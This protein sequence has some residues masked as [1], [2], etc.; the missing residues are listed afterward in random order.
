[1]IK[2][3]DNNFIITLIAF[4]TT[5]YLLFLIRNIILP[6]D[7]SPLYHIIG[8]TALLLFLGVILIAEKNNKKLKSQIT[9]LE[10]ELIKRDEKY[11]SEIEQLS[12]NLEEYEKEKNESKKFA[13]YRDKMLK[14]LFSKAR[15]DH[16]FLHLLCES[17]QA[18]AALLYKLDEQCNKF[19]VQESYAVPE[20]Y[21][22]PTFNY[23]EGLSGQAAKDQMPME[24]E[25]IP[26]D[27]LSIESGLGKSKGSCLYILPVNKNDKTVFIIELLTFKKS[28]I[29]KMWGDIAKNIIKNRIL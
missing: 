3:R 25:D 16:N 14:E 4:S 6:V 12:K 8:I 11:K 18:G 15:G 9:E 23:N 5:G 29:V 7:A 21:N 13:S 28:N 10:K 26:G 24:V 17:F 20:D 19:I 22:P 27:Y 1:M 2:N